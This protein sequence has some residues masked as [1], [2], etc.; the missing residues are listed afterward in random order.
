MSSPVP[1]NSDFSLTAFAG[2]TYL[3]LSAKEI[4]STGIFANTLAHSPNGRFMTVVGDGEYIMYTVLA[5][6]NKSFG[7]GLSFAWAPDSN[8]YVVL[9]SRVKLEVFKNFKEQAGVRSKPKMWG[10]KS[11]YILH[12]NQDAYNTKV[13]EGAELTDERFEEALEVVTDMSDKWVS[14]STIPFMLAKR[15]WVSKLASG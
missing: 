15:L 12:L 1:S 11:C 8:A 5:W 7:N 6:R 3:S 14:L 13:E 4:A 2:G 9:E 10:L